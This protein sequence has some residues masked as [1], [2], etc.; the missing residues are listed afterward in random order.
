MWNSR[1]EIILLEN[2][3]LFLHHHTASV[4]IFRDTETFW[5]LFVHRLFPGC[6]EISHWSVCYG[7]IYFFSVCWTLSGLLI[8]KLI[9]Q[10]WKIFLNNFIEFFPVVPF[11]DT[12]LNFGICEIFVFLYFYFIFL[13]SRRLLQNFTIN[14]IDFFLIYIIVLIFKN[15]LFP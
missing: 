1:E 4:S 8:R 10:L 14:F 6:S 13:L 2:L 3:T 9:L 7:C 15:F 12:Y 5:W 11:G